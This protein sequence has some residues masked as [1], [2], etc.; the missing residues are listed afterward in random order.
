LVK[1]LAMGAIGVGGAEASGEDKVRKY[2][3]DVMDGHKLPSLPIVANKVLEM[4]KDP[5]VNMQKL[6]RVLADDT[7]LAAR[8]LT[9]SRSPQYA[10][11]NL[12]TTLLG[13]VQVLGFRTL[14]SVV[15]ANATHS[16]C[17]KGN[18]TSEKLWNHSLGVALAMR[19]LS[20]RAGLRDR[21]LAFLTGLMH[22]VGQII[23]IQGDPTGYE[24]LVQGNGDAATP[25][26]DKEQAQYGLDHSVMGFSL[27]GHW[28]MDPQLAQAAFN[29]HSELGDDPANQMA[30]M[31]AVADYFCS[32]CEMGF[33]TEPPTPSAEALGRYGMADE[34]SA[35]EFSG[36]IQ[37]AYREESALFNAA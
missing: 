16:L 35:G 21:D 22:D 34:Q 4:L 5:D 27:L 26:V 24:K 37:Q 23:L 31:V 15:I 14:T 9:V 2:Y 19:L 33:F 25:I 3:R 13:A 12:P 10:L 36:E 11:R 20:K 18:K 6:C 29:H 17:I 30:E 32:Q 1:E 28:N 7:A 8:V